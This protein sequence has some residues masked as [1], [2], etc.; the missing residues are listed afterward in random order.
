MVEK[1]KMVKLSNSF[2][3]RVPKQIVSVFNLYNKDYSFEF[4]INKDGS[5]IIY[6]RDENGK[7]NK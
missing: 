4:K 1:I 5:T 6:K 2:Y 3:L 7:Q